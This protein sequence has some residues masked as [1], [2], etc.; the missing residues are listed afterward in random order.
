MIRKTRI[1]TGVDDGGFSGEGKVVDVRLF[2]AFLS[3]GYV[4]FRLG[5]GNV[6]VDLVSKGGCLGEVS[7]EIAAEKDLNIAMVKMWKI[8]EKLILNI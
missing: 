4:F 6:E 2:G 1:K 7:V 3:S 8:I 5:L